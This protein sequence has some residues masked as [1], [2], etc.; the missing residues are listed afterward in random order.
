MGW[1]DTDVAQRLQGYLHTIMQVGRESLVIGGLTLYLEGFDPDVGANYALPNR[2]NPNITPS[3][4]ERIERVSA[5]RAQLIC[6]Q[7]LDTYAP[8]L[9]KQ[10]S[11]M[12]YVQQEALPLLVCQPGQLRPPAEG[13]ALEF[14]V[15][16]EEA[17]LED[18]AEHWNINQRGFNPLPMLVEPNEVEYFRS[19]LTT[20]RAFTARLDGMGVSSGMYTDIRDGVTELMG[21][22]TLQAYRRRGIGGALTAFAT[23][24]AFADGA[25]LAFLT[26]ASEEASRVYQRVG[27]GLVGDLVLMAKRLT[28]S[29]T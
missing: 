20:S 1:I 22:A 15:M 19:T 17:S 24:S 25:T 18:L 28:T 14:V 2:P 3:A 7:W 16:N 5:K 13:A 8:G 29:D 10:L 27:F 26:A 23:Q 6:F 21:I 12:G 4:F 11:G 9:T